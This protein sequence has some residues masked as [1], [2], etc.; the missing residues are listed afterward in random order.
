M[1]VPCCKAYHGHIDLLL[2]GMRMHLEFGEYMTDITS[3]E[4]DT[5]LVRILE[6]TTAAD[7]I[8]VPGIYE[9]LAEYYNNEVLR[10]YEDG[11]EDDV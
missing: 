10:I 9:I 2:Y 4:F 11:C 5:I 7:L 8:F 3:Q 6:K 1:W